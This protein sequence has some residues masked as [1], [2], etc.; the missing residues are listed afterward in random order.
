[1]TDKKVLRS[2]TDQT[3]QTPEQ[4]KWL[5]KL[6]GYDFFIDYNLGKKM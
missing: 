4:Q 3:I 6:L 5:H 1:M 2:L